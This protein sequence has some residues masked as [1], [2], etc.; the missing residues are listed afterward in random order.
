MIMN[1]VYATIAFFNSKLD[2]LTKKFVE[3]LL[4][5]GDSIYFFNGTNLLAR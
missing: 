1:N 4:D 2:S 5:I 3:A